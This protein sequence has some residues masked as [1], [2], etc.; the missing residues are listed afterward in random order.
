MNINQIYRDIES[1]QDD[2]DKCIKY[3]AIINHLEAVK[4]SIGFERTNIQLI[5]DINNIVKEETITQ[6]DIIID[7][8]IKFIKLLVN[9][10]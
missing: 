2:V 9:K 6:I 4:R 8:C 10:K 7:D 3:S 5:D 1:I